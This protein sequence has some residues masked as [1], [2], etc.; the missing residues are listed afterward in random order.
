MTDICLLMA[1]IT[2]GVTFNGQIIISLDPD[3]PSTGTDALIGYALIAGLFSSMIC[4]LLSAMMRTS[5]G[6]R[7]KIYNVVK[8]GKELQILKEW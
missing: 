1:V 8:S 3:V 4:Y 2:V 6:Q 7:K 5:V